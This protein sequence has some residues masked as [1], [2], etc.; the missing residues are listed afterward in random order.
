MQGKLVCLREM[1]DMCVRACVCVSYDNHLQNQP[2]KEKRLVF[3]FV[4]EHLIVFILCSGLR[5]QGNM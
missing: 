5:T 2:A 4:T 1:I 3:S